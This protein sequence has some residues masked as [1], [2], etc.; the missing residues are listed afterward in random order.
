MF[1]LT[2]VDLEN[3]TRIS[4]WEFEKMNVQNNIFAFF[5]ARYTIKFTE[6]E[7]NHFINEPWHTNLYMNII[8]SNWHNSRFVSTKMKFLLYFCSL[9]D[10]WPPTTLIPLVHNS[11]GELEWCEIRAFKILKMRKMN[12]SWNIKTKCVTDFLLSVRS[13]SM[14]DYTCHYVVST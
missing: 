3:E 7:W 4:T 13:S 14:K 1:T 8:N 5:S 12:V 6:Q 9:H 2:F 10:Y 11:L